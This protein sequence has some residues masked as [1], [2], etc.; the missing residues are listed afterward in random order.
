MLNICFAGFIGSESFLEK[1]SDVV[2]D[3]KKEN[4]HLIY[5]K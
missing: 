1:V 2:K 3:L 4:P 5:G